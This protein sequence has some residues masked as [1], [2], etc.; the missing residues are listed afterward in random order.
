M[1]SVL[2]GLVAALA[3]LAGP[4]VATEPA[5]DGTR[6]VRNVAELRAALDGGVAATTVR[7]L[8]GDYPLD[9]PLVVPDGVLLEGI[10]T[11][12]VRDGR[13]AG[14]DAGP[15]TVIRAA[16]SFDGD[17]VTL[18]NDARVRSLLLL[19]QTPS[20]GAAL[21]QG[22]VVALVSRSAG[23]RLSARIED[24]E[25]VSG[26]AMGVTTRGPVG[27]GIVVLT[28]SPSLGESGQPHVGSTVS[29]HL[30]RSRV[31]ARGASL[32]VVN[33]ASRSEI[34]VTLEGNLMAG[35]IVASGGAS[36]PQL[37]SGSRVHLHSSGNLYQHSDEGE[38]SF[39]WML[40]GGSTP[41]LPSL[42]TPGPRD[43]EL[44]MQSNGDRIE[45]FRIGVLAGGARRRYEIAGPPI[46]NRARL[47]LVDLSI[48]T[49]GDRPLGVA[50][51]GAIAG[52]GDV[53]IAGPGFPA[54]EGNVLWARMRSMRVDEPQVGN[55]YSAT[56][57]DPR[58]DPAAGT[59]RLV[60]AGT[61]ED[62][63]RD[64]PGFPP[65]PPDAFD[66]VDTRDR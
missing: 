25:I 18:G 65:P 41:H 51:H 2:S 32:F 16:R 4:A 58:M 17:L 29:L 62:F 45:G 63:A 37:V 54:G 30:S 47:D 24:C 9:R 35:P 42:A 39:G 21:R 61:A 53:A 59:N 5:L 40:Y 28:R 10:G 7:L 55:R 46:D 33:F 20:R 38:D 3:T 14:F 31:Q 60:L 44:S 43:N 22:N 56:F 19:D 6:T 11:M 49:H 13:A 66:D 1:R 26:G 12:A 48:S 23:D 50:L 34:E 57:G 8:A 64:N 36:R 15:V 52:E 27:H